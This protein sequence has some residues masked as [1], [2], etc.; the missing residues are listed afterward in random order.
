MAGSGVR[1]GQTGVAVGRG[2]WGDC[3]PASVP[4]SNGTSHIKTQRIFR[5]PQ[6]AYSMPRDTLKANIEAKDL[7]EKSL[8]PTSAVNSLA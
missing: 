2:V 6:R 5:S 7:N 3:A 1:L 8:L 4:K